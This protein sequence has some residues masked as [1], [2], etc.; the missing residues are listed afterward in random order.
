MKYYNI[1]KLLSKNAKYSMVFGERSNGKTYAILEYGL[2][3]Y[4]KTGKQIAILRRWK[5]DFRGKRAAAYFD[6]LVCNGNEENKV[7]EITNGRYSTITYNA[8]KWFLSNYDQEQDKFINAPQ[9]FAFAFALSDQEHE[10]GNSY[11]NVGMIFLD[12]YQTR[13]LYLPDEFVLFMNTISTIVRGRDN[14]KIFM[15]ANT[16][17]QYC[18]Y[19]EEMGLTH[20]RKMKRGDID[21]YKYGESGLTVAIEYADSPNTFKASDVYF[22]FDNPKLKMIT[23]GA[24]ELDIYPHLINK[25]K[26]KEIQFSYFV[27]FKENILQADIVVRDNEAFTF[28]HKKTTPIKYEDKDIVFTTEADQRNNYFGRLTKPINKAGKKL[29]YFFVNNKVFYASNEV[30]E[31]MSHYL[32]WSNN[33]IK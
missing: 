1:K 15:A 23:Q 25:Y 3:Q 9:P 32:D 30:G 29:L 10:K 31:I 33:L 26:E 19:H 8:G 13:G 5:E 16:V 14:V 28:V 21:V 22:A 2:Q 20:V 11:P 17:S 27:I 24:W 18:P 12:E 4:V 7:Y 6:N